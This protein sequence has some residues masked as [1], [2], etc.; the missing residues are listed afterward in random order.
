MRGLS[1]SSG[2]GPNLPGQKFEL[3]PG[4]SFT[5]VLVPSIGTDR[6]EKPGNYTLR[7]KDRLADAF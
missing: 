4:E 3:K 2:G 5:Q 1:L 6:F 7:F